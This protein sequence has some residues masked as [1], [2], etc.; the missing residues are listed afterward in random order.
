MAVPKKKTSKSKRNQR[1]AHDGL[2]RIN[3]VVDKDTG[4]YRLS[5]N[6]DKSSGAYN[7]RQ[8]VI[9]K[10]KDETNAE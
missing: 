7:N 3:A 10:I 5:H 1:R 9:S 8:I 6:I 2:V 4:E